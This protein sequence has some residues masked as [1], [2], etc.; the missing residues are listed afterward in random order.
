MTLGGA[1]HESG[2]SPVFRRDGHETERSGTRDF[3]SRL[4]I[5]ARL[6]AVPSIEVEVGLQPLLRVEDFQRLKALVARPSAARLKPCPDTEP[7]DVSLLRRTPNSRLCRL[8]SPRHDASADVQ[9]HTLFHQLHGL[10]GDRGYAPGALAEDAGD[11]AGLVDDF[12]IA[13]LERF[14]VGDGHVGHLLL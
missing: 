5:R 8:D 9:P 6:R 4:C 12:A 3:P 2:E 14:E 7:S 10:I 11:V 1:R 13:L